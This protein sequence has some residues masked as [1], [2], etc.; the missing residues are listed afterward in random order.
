MIAINKKN[1]KKRN[2]KKARTGVEW[3]IESGI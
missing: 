1:I 2:K 3:K